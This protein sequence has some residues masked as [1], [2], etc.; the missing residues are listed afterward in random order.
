MT[1][2]T[3]ALGS[4]AIRRFGV[5]IAGMTVRY[6]YA[7]NVITMGA[8]SKSRFFAYH[9]R[10]YPKELALFGAPGT[11]GAPCAQNDTVF[12]CAQNDTAFSCAQNDTVFSCA[13]NDTA[14]C[15]GCN[16]KRRAGV[17]ATRGACT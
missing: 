16:W 10:T 4:R 13:Q 2:C 15:V 3:S 17:M 12:S 9:P 1:S 6:R 14:L 5:L 11:F 8:S 7:R